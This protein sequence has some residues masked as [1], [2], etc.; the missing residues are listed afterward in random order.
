MMNPQTKFM[1]V[2]LFLDRDAKSLPADILGFDEEDPRWRL[3]Q[4]ILASRTFSKSVRLSNFLSYI[5]RRTLEGRTQE[6]NE[7]QIGTHVFSRSPSY[8]ANDDSIV[9]TQARLLRLKLD[10]YFEHERPG[11]P[12]IL[13]IPKGGYVPIFEQRP[14][15]VEISET[16]VKPSPIEAPSHTVS[17]EVDVPVTPQ[18]LPFSVWIGIAV[19]LL[20]IGVTVDIALRISS[21]AQSAAAP[22]ALW[23][24]MFGQNQVTVIVPSDDALVLFQESTKT[25]VFLDAYLSGSYL[26]KVPVAAGSVPLTANWLNS[27]QYTSMADLNIA[28]QLQRLPEALRARTEVRYARDLR[29][30]DL[31][32][33]N[34]VLIGGI[35]ANPWVELFENQLNFDVNYDW[36]SDEGYV[37]NRSPKEGEQKLYR[38]ITAD[39]SRH[40]YGVLA[41]LPGIEGRGEVLLIQG[42]GMAGTESAAEFPLNE[43]AFKGF[44]KQ[45][46]AASNKLPHFEV[47]LETASIGGNA[48][49]AKIVTYRL[50]NP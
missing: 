17:P 29:M 45:I 41:F 5:C 21:S 31:K 2:Q 48:P 18:K 36:K 40:N 13:R 30:D 44:L 37:L 4:D 19:L 8:N 25:R 23:S 50:L 46:G 11:A 43:D 10:E 47:L 6:I 16:A 27:H 1:R 32:Y 38:E 42:S 24:R 9:R 28:L 22:H 3:V 12:L 26:E 14:A 7:Q 35:G 20:L 49:Q 15:A 39:G 33:K 34:A